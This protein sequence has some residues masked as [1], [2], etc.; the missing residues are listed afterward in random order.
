MYKLPFLLD[1]LEPNFIVI[2]D[3]EIS[4]LNAT[5]ASTAGDILSFPKPVRLHS[6]TSTVFSSLSMCNSCSRHGSVLVRGTM[7]EDWLTLQVRSPDVK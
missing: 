2:S 4:S 5:T 1:G 6:M 3:V 7:S